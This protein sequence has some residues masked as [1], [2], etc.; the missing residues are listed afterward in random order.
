MA[1]RRDSRDGTW[2]YRKVVKLP[3]GRKVRIN[4]TPAINTK[5]AAEAAERAHIIRALDPTAERKEVPTFEEFVDD[6]WWPT[7]PAAAGNRSSTR[8]EKEI[9]LRLH[10]KPRLGEVRLDKV[11]GEVIGKLLASL[12]DKGLS[13]KSVKNVQATLRRILAS[14]VEWGYLEG[15]PT[16][17]RV[18][19]PQPRWDFLTAE[20]STKLVGVARTD[21]E[22]A[23]LVF[24]LHTGARAGEQIAIEWADID[25]TNRLVV[26]RR[27][28]TRGE[29]GPTKSGK[30][31]RVPLT[32]TLERALRQVRHLRGPRVFCNPD[33][34]PLRIGQMHERLW[35]ACRRAGLRR[36]RWH[37]LR[38]SFASQ[39]ATAGVPLRQV[40]EWLGHSTINMTMRYAHLAPGGGA[41]LI[42]ALELPAV[43]IA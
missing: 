16:L 2:R 11:R 3:D 14:A 27:S 36:M 42:R 4:G 39:L 34:S 5:Q 8:T 28:S 41:N 33:G 17:P 19:V 9:H 38:H 35:G 7:Y 10:L 20:E 18:K 31:R 30:E 15:V 40:Q 1:V 22:R 23:I 25:W 43:A 24:A 13:E 37:D 6:R 12:R 32:G 29:V 26:L 21:E